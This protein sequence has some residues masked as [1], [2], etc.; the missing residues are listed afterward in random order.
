M[1]KYAVPESFIQKMES[2]QTQYGN[3]VF[4]VGQIVDNGVYI[5]RT[6]VYGNPFP[7][8]SENCK[9]VQD[10]INERIRVCYEYYLYITDQVR[11]QSEITHAQ[12]RY[13]TGSNLICHCNDGTNTID[14]HHFCHGLVLA[15][16]IDHV[17]HEV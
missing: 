15:K 16:A 1:S 14:H 8:K 6:T 3:K 17:N 5:G 11:T 10:S 7:M 2:W 9:T 12:I 13:L 4:K